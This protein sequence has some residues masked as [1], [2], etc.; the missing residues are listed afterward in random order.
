[1]ITSREGAVGAWERPEDAPAHYETDSIGLWSSQFK[2][3]AL[4]AELLSGLLYDGAESSVALRYQTHEKPVT[5]SLVHMFR[6]R[7]I[8]FRDQ[9]EFVNNYAAL[10]VERSEEILVQRADILSFLEGAGALR[11]TAMPKTMELLGLVTQTTL[12]VH[13]RIK[14]A[15]ACRRPIEYSPQIQPMIATP[16]HGA[17]PSGHATEGFT[18]AFFLEALIREASGVKGGFN[19]NDVRTVQFMRIAE[20]IATNRVVAGV[21]FPVDS[22]AGMVLAQALSDFFVA[23]FVGGSVTSRTFDGRGFNDD[24]VYNKV[25]ER[26]YRSRDGKP[27]I[28]LEDQTFEPARSGLLKGVWDQAVDECQKFYR[29]GRAK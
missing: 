7:E 4:Q 27:V 13:A 9:M 10:R 21:H 18:S 16:G 22:V 25:L 11:P 29:A 23:R 1:L 8:D 26:S 15:L 24:F 12:M 28:R 14:H 6:P 19:K 17:L 2:V 20:R 3:L 5:Y